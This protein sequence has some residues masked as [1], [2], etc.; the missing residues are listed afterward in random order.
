MRSRKTFWAACAALLSLISVQSA[1]YAGT[2]FHSGHLRITNFKHF[3]ITSPPPVQTAGTVNVR[4]F[5]ATGDG[6]TDDTAAIQNAIAAAKANGQGVLFPAGTYL[7]ASVITANGVAL[8]GIGGASTLL[9]NNPASSAVILS[10]VSPSIQNIVVNSGPA[11]NSSFGYSPNTATLAVSGAQN[12]VVQGI[13][14]VQGQS[15]PGVILQQSAVGQVAGVTFNSSGSGI[16]VGIAMD[17]CANTTI[18]GN[19]VLNEV[20]GII[21][22]T[23]SGFTSNSIAVIGNTVTV[24][25]GAGISADLVF[26][27]DIEQN[28]I[29]GLTINNTPLQIVRSSNYQISK[30]TI[31]TGII[32]IV[33]QNYNDGNTGVIFQNVIRNC[34]AFAASLLVSGTGASMQFLSNSF[35]ECGLNQAVPVLRCNASTGPDSLV[36]LNNVYAGHANM[37]TSYIYSDNHVNLVAGNAQTQTALP[38]S[39]P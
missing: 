21:L 10:G 17:G 13:T 38:N 9:A 23:G 33:A 3:K 35:G 36:I 19:L 20:F 30:N 25:D 5:G 28:Q 29:Q 15:R 1:S 16:D 39:I 14:I 18:L 11:G 7:H 37:L 8:I 27:L 34:D 22:G 26:I 6:T 12:F 24:H 32:G 4:D 2:A 31:S